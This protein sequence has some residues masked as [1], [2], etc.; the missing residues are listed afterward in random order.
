MIRS[1]LS[2]SLLP[3]LALALAACG[4]PETPEPATPV[5]P[6]ATA[7]AATL[8]AA[9]QAAPAGL[10][11]ALRGLHADDGA[12]TYAHASVDLNGDGSDE[13]LAYVMGPMVCGSGGCNLYVLAQEGQ[14]GGEGWRV[15]T[16]TSVTQTPV[17]VLTTSTNGWR[18]LAVSI[19]GGGGQAGWVR[20]TYDGRTYPTNPTAPPATPLEGQPDVTTLIASEPDARPLP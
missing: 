13:V 2:V 11:A 4:Q 15:V 17:G 8:P 12:L 19:G 20:L 1:A 14:D 9:S 16:R 6:A 5:A 7:P 18:D 10:E 3:M